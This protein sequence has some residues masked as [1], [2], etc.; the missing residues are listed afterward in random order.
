[1]AKQVIKAQLGRPIRRSERIILFL[2]PQRQTGVPVN[3][4][5]EI[6]AASLR[7]AFTAIVREPDGAD[8]TI[9]PKRF[10]KG[11]IRFVCPVPEPLSPPIDLGI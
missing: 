11:T 3:V 6:A 10:A 2:S 7:L 4:A 5:H 9:R 1:M 8:M